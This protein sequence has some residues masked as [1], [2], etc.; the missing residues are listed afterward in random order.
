MQDVDATV[1]VRHPM[2]ASSRERRL[3][4]SGSL[5]GFDEVRGSNSLAEPLILTLLSTAMTGFPRGDPDFA[6]LSIMAAPGGLCTQGATP[7]L[8]H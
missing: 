1:L 3:R 8:L 7:G 2:A 4:V 6:V 5:Q